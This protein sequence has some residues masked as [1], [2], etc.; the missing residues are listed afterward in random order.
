MQAY[1]YLLTSNFLGLQW[2]LLLDKKVHNCIL[3]LRKQAVGMHSFYLLNI[4]IINHS[5]VKYQ[6]GV[7]KY[8]NKCS[9]PWKSLVKGDR[10]ICSEEK[11]EYPSDKVFLINLEQKQYFPRTLCL[12]AD[13]KVYLH[14]TTWCR[15][16]GSVL[17]L[18]SN[19]ALIIY[20]AH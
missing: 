5:L 6:G 7:Q 10:L 18:I 8:K 2:S 17:L 4:I 13:H 19:I 1:T 11:T 14:Y 12:E 15:M 3:S 20:V 16:S 9:S